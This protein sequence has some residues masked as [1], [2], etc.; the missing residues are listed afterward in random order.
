VTV[1][2]LD[3][4]GHDPQLIV[5]AAEVENPDISNKLPEVH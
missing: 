5:D 1:T 4:V 3:P 2:E